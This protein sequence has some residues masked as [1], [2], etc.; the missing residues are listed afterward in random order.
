MS[1][2]HRTAIIRFSRQMSRDLTPDKNAYLERILASR[3]DLPPDLETLTTLQRRHLESVPFEN[4]DI[5]WERPITLDTNRF[6]EKIV[7]NKRG[8]FCYELNGLFE[9]LLRSLGFQTRLISARP[10]S[11]ESGRFGPEFD[12]AAIIITIANAE[13]LVDVGFG[14][15]AAAPLKIAEGEDQ[16]DRE[17]LFRIRGA[18]NGTLFAEKKI[19]GKW[20]PEY[21]F[22]PVVRELAEFTEMCDH[23]QYSPESHFRKGKICSVLTADGRKTLTDKNFIV[24]SRGKRTESPVRTEAEFDEIVE[25]EFGIRRP[26][27]NKQ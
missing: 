11:Q 16:T 14:D 5:H 17:G 22:A 3:I 6:F 15:F 19:A 18:S 4:L 8:G 12:H 9:S 24:T 25:R 7:T 1:F 10:Y 21:M 23:Q 26:S 20:T 2:Y 13:Y 27:Q